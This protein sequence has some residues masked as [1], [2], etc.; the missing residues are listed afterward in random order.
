MTGP[1]SRRLRP[2]RPWWP[3]ATAAG[4]AVIVTLAVPVVAPLQFAYPAPSLRI[5][6]DTGVAVIALLATAI[7]VRGWRDGLRVDRL[8]IAAGLALI[9]VT[10]AVTDDARQPRR[11]GQGPRALIAITGTF[12][13]SALLGAGAF[14]PARPVRT[15][16]TAVLSMIGITVG[17]VAVVAGPAAFALAQ[18]PISPIGVD[19]A[20]P[21]ADQPLAALA[22]QLA[23]AVGFALAAIGLTERGVRCGDAFTRRLGLAV[24]LFA[25]AKLHYALLPPIAQWVHVG[26]VL[27]LLFCLML[28][29][30]AVVEVV[31]T[32][33]TRAAESERLRIARDLHDGVAQELAFIRQAG[34][35]RR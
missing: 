12:V 15:P 14:A 32:V 17:A 35:R 34:P 10:F 33:A 28:L 6:L 27:R 30:T 22:L 8:I 29:W 1:V 21:G 26:D 24:L 19:V 13:G 3:F 2:T 11:L 16:R 31:R 25:F 23:G 9:A 20:R 5:A 7:V 4:A 18:D